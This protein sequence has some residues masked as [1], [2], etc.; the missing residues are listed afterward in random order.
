MFKV[1]WPET[2]A[3]VEFEVPGNPVP[4]KASCFSRQLMGSGRPA[5]Y[6]DKGLSLYQQRV[7]EAGRMAAHQQGWLLGYAGDAKLEL[8]LCFVEK[9]KRGEPIPDNTNVQKSLEDALQNMTIHGLKRSG[10]LANDRKI[11]INS[12]TRAWAPRNLVQ[13]RLSALATHPTTDCTSCGS[14][15]TAALELEMSSSAPA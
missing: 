10:L 9:R 5:A 11:C 2:L 13:I 15:P 14:S 7:A 8:V 3:I 12:T 1:V 6:K 4:W